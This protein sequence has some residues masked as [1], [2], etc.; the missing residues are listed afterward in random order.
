MKQERQ[1]AKKQVTINL[2]LLPPQQTER[3]KIESIV[4]DAMRSRGFYVK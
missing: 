2:F 4:K 1:A 3:Q